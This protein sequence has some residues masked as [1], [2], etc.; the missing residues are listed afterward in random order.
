MADEILKELADR[1]FAAAVR[2]TGARD[3]RDFYRARLREIRERDESAF[4]KALDYFEGVLVPGVA[5]EGSD[6]IGEWLD[7][8][9]FLANLR[10]PGSPVEIDRSGRS[11]PYRRPVPTDHLVL[12]LPTS[13]RER[14]LAVG[15][16]PELSEAQ[17]ATYRLLVRGDDESQG[18]LAGP[19]HP[20]A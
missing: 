6:P 8:G 14:A 3:P 12:H 10:E 11:R 9:C 13:G 18:F 15:L 4:G 17:R 16:P 5:R 7:Y 1:R 19:D 2:D 20:P